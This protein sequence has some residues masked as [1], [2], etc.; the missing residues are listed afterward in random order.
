MVSLLFEHNG[1]SLKRSYSIASSPEKLA[2]E[3]LLEIAIG[4]VSDGSASECF[5]RAQPGEQFEITGPFGI[6]TLPEELPD[7][8][9]LAGT[10]TGMAPYR[11]MLPQL[12]QLQ[13]QGQRIHILMGARS[14]DDLFYQDDFRALA[15]ASG[16]VT[17]EACLSREEALDVSAGEKKG[18]VQQR[19]SELGLTPGED[20]VYLCGNPHMIDDSVKWLTEQGFGPR[21]NQEGKI[22][23]L[24]IM[25]S[26]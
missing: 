26:V 5:S 4:L 14:R 22:Y 2:R 16:N 13:Q 20:L 7:R 19:F 24:S 8:L 11:A 21:Q 6:L 17:Y 3:G 25:L 10:G 23:L 9:M 12:E 18:Y 1:E 15:E